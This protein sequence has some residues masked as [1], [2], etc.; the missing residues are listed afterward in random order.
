VGS[1]HSSICATNPI[2]LSSR[3]NGNPQ[4][5]FVIPHFGAGYLKEALMVASQCSNVDLDTP[6]ATVDAYSGVDLKEVFGRALAAAGPQR[7]TFWDGFV[8][9]SAWLEQVCFHRASRGSTWLG[10]GH[11]DARPFWAAT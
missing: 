5:N 9:F 10:I 7:L 11:E 1:S 3:G 8:L 6:A 4:V 2:D